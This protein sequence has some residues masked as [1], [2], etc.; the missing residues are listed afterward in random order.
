MYDLDFLCTIV[1]VMR[2]KMYRDEGSVNHKIIIQVF[3]YLVQLWDKL[4]A[5]FPENLNS[6]LCFLMSII[7]GEK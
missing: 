1:N 6:A 7:L 3:H 4:A 5:V 2:W